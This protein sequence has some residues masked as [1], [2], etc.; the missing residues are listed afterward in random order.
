MLITVYVTVFSS[1]PFLS[2]DLLVFSTESATEAEYRDLVSELKILIHIGEH[3]NIVNLL[4]AC[5]KGKWTKS[6]YTKI[7][8]SHVTSHSRQWWDFVLAK[9]SWSWSPL[10]LAF[11]GLIL[12]IKFLLLR[13]WT[14]SV[15]YNRI[16]SPWQLAW[17]SAQAPWN[18][19]SDMDHAHWARWRNIYN[20]WSLY[21]CFASC[22]CNGISSFKTGKSL[23]FFLSTH[24][25]IKNIFYDQTRFQLVV[26]K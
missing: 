19:R 20:D 6:W 23:P 26:E 21:L 13:S 18:F 22:T 3:K 4:G 1:K 25:L 8:F 16:L 2:T 10:I 24:N 15:G 9:I 7:S 12:R 5:T 11:H 17:L 14:G